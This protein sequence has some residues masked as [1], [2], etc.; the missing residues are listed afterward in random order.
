MSEEN[1]NGIQDVLQ[2][3]MRLLVDF[4]EGGSGGDYSSRIEDIDDEQLMI[5][6][7][8]NR[9]RPINVAKGMILTISAVAGGGKFS[10]DSRVITIVK[11][12]IYMLVVTLPDV[13]LHEQ[14][15]EFYRVP[16]HL[17]VKVFLGN[18][19]KLNIFNKTSR[20]VPFEEGLIDD[21]SGGGCRL[22]CDVALIEGDTIVV[23]LSSTLVEG[24]KQ[25]E[26]RAVRVAF[27]P[28]GKRII[29]LRYVNITEM[30][31]DNIIRYVFRRQLELKKLSGEA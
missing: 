26:C 22:S 6:M 1:T 21:L 14:M 25:I 10:F 9:G 7:P 20:T 28:N 24:V 30:D 15:R 13:L 2:R 18:L 11:T 31:R 12:P 23:D 19:D 17:R 3:N 29:S 27:R 4:A 5:S 8:T 16:V